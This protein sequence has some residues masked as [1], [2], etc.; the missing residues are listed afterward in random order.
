[1]HDSDPIHSDDH[2]AFEKENV[3][4]P[5]CNRWVRRDAE[6]CLNCGR[7]FRDGTR[8]TDFLVREPQIKASLARTISEQGAPQGRPPLPL[9][10]LLLA[11]LALAALALV[12]GILLGASF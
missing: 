6:E 11:A 7:P 5:T 10:Y 12:L 3:K 1:M 9:I 4:C 8:L 2:E